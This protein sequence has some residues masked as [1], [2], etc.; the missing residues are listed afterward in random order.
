VTVER[1]SHKHAII[2][3]PPLNH[4]YTELV[5]GLTRHFCEHLNLLPV[6]NGFCAFNIPQFD[7][8][9]GAS[10]QYAGVNERLNNNYKLSLTIDIQDSQLKE[11]LLLQHV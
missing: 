8:G 10:R 11:N 2:K 3:R 1:R 5:A 7:T 4:R 6:V 9:I